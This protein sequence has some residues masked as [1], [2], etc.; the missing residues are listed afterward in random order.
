MTDAAR[1]ADTRR[2]FD[3]LADAFIQEGVDTVFALMGDANMYWATRMADRG[4]RLTYVRHE[5][6]AVAAAL[7]YA[8]L[9]GKVGVATVTCGPGLTNTLTALPAAAI[10]RVPLVIFA[11]EPPLKAAWYNQM[12]EQ[13]P[14]VLASGA[15]YHRMHDPARFTQTVRDAFIQAQVERRP[16]VLGVP[17]DLQDLPAAE[18]TLPQPAALLLQK[19][20]PAAPDHRVISELVEQ[21]GAARRVVVLGGLGAQGAVSQARLLAER[22]DAL[23]ATTL[24]ARGL[25]N[26]DPFSVGIAG[27]LS[28]PLAAELLAEADIVLAFGASLAH[29][30]SMGGK[31][32]PRART[33]QVDTDPQVLNQGRAV[34][35]LFVQADA[36]SAIEALL[37]RLPA[38]ASRWRT[39]EL[40]E[41]LRQAPAFSETMDRDDQGAFDPRQVVM[42]LDAVIPPDWTIV[43]TSGHVSSFTA[44]MQ[45]RPFGRFL[46]IREF[47]AIG[48]GTSFALGAAAARRGEP[49]VLLDGDGSLLMHI[50]ELETVARH[51]LPVLVVVL[52]DGAYGSEIHKLRA[53]GMSDAGAVFGSPD[54]ETIARGF[55]FT[56]ERL[57]DLGRLDVLMAGFAASRVPS[58]IDIPIRQDVVSGQ[59]KRL[60]ASKS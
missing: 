2:N 18:A 13:A 17:M 35:D 8:R 23:L 38:R 26:D 51:N 60:A 42:A 56:G 46:T 43:N 9:S 12:I 15:A 25:F 22:C 7:A 36:S 39:P 14:F 11:G 16:V 30:T 24:P 29:H 19:R 50:Q 49:V 53:R 20:Y 45:H 54:F 33:V 1:F 41:R 10:A 44:Q 55:G 3:L 57:G 32:W 21:I 4:C 37:E 59:M 40:A 28:S 6:A 34:A 5:H 31:V 52:N 27:G 58:L 47:G 48:N